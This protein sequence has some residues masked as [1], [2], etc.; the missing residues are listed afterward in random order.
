MTTPSETPTS[1]AAAPIP[2]RPQE[3]LFISD[4]HL[5]EDRPDL[6]ALFLDFLAGRAQGAGALF[7]LGD[8]FDA[9][10][11]DDDDRPS[12]RAVIDALRHLADQGTACALMHGN[13]DFLIGRRFARAAGCRLLRDPACIRLGGEP[14]LLM[15]GDLLCTDDIPY[16]RFRRR[17]RN[18]IVQRLFLLKSLAARRQIAA[19]YRARSGAAT[20]EKTQAIMDVNPAEVARRIRRAKVRRL[21]H[22]HTHRPA[23]HD[24]QLADQLAHR[25][26]LS[27]WHA[28]RGE[29]LV[30]D[31]TGWHREPVFPGHARRLG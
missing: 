8:L 25:H 28:H 31:D 17:V 5:S 3:T 1:T 18:P 30:H 6:L 7:I 16:Q 23:D 9:W 10:I 11:G 12:H 29:V 2:T 24:L 21:V 22:G 13:R 4:L 19:D 15:H 26:A 14:V 27:D 20:A